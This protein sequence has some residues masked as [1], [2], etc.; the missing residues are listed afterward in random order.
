ML[1]SLLNYTYQE[2]TTTYK[3]IEEMDLDRASTAFYQ[4][5]FEN[6]CDIAFKLDAYFQSKCNATGVYQTQG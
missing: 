2:M 3:E 4:R 1:S 5:I 6:A